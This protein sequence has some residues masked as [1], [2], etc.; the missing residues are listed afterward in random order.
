MLPLPSNAGSWLTDELWKQF[1][2]EP[3]GVDWNHLLLALVELESGYNW[4][5]SAKGLLT[6]FRPK[7]IGEW[8]NSGRKA[9][10]KYRNVGNEATFGGNWWTW[11]VTMQPAW[12]ELVDG[13][14]K[15]EMDEGANWGGMVVPGKNGM[16]SVIAGLYWWGYSMRR[17]C[18]R[19]W[20]RWKDAVRDVVWVLERLTDVAGAANERNE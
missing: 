15:R 19:L 14:P 10:V 7:Q 11:W 8:V 6:A 4:E 12:R 16:L 5:T 2:A 20:A 1:A 3:L 13:T 9:D 17:Q 18:V